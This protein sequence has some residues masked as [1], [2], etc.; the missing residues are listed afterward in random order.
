MSR[1]EIDDGLMFFGAFLCI[2]RERVPRGRVRRLRLARFLHLEETAAPLAE[3]SFR[4]DSAGYTAQ[5]TDA[6]EKRTLSIR[7]IRAMTTSK[8]RVFSL[9]AERGGSSAPLGRTGHSN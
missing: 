1:Q 7:G 5:G 8:C 6:A 3:L 9:L 4:K 2:A